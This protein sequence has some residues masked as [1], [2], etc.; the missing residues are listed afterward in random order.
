MN[1]LLWASVGCF[2][3]GLLSFAWGK[4]RPEDQ[5]VTDIVSASLMCLTL[6]GL[7]LQAVLGLPIN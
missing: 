4:L 2:L 3:G 6:A 7:M 1:S 5:F